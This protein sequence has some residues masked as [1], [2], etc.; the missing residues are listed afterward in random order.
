MKQ[1]EYCQAVSASFGLWSFL[2]LGLMAAPVISF[3][4]NSQI[5]ASLALTP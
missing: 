2:G 1:L 4:F 5:D 3:G